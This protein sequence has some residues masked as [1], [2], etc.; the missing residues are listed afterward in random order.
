MMLGILD[1]VFNVCVKILVALLCE[2]NSTW[3]G[4]SMLICIYWCS[5]GLSL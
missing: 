1:F 3:C 4:S 2:Q 5:C